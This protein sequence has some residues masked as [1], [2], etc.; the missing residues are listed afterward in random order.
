[1][2]DRELKKQDSIKDAK[3]VK[4]ESQLLL[5]EGSDSFDSL[6]SKVGESIEDTSIPTTYTMN[7]CKEYFID[8]RSILLGNII[9]SKK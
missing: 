1:M 9:T 3:N 4:L 6:N 8:F 7:V 5:I 2:D